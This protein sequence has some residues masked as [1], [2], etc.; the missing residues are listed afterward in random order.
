MIKKKSF[1]RRSTP[2]QFQHW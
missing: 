2:C 1:N